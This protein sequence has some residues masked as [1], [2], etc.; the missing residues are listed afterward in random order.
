MA[1]ATADIHI[2][3]D[4]RV[5]TEAEKNFAKCGTTMSRFINDA[6]RSFN[7]NFKENNAEYEKYSVPENLRIE[8]REQLVNILRNRILADGSTYYDVA[9]AKE[10]ILGGNSKAHQ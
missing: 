10:I 6:L 8:T 7:S 3:I 2:K 1:I 4:P 5:K 9:E